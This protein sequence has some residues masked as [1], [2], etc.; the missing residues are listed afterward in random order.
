M[1]L[2]ANAERFSGF[3]DLYDE[4]RP[5]PPREIARLLCAY[6]AVDRPALVVDLG[7]GTGLSSR[8]CASWAAQV[9]GVEPSEDMRT[10][11]ERAT[12]SAAAGRRVRY[13]SGWSHATGLPPGRADVVVAVQALHWMDPRPTFAEV[14]RLLRAGGVFAA[15]DCDWPPSVGSARAEQAWERCRG[16]I[17]VYEARLA[18][19]LG[20]PALRAPLD[21]DASL[22]E[23]FGRDPNKGRTM[24]VGVQAWSK[25]EHLGRMRAS[26]EFQWCGEVC[27]LSRE[28][29]DADRFIALL[30]SQGDLQ[31]L[32]KHGL[33]EQL[34]GVDSFA[35]DAR[36][37]LGPGARPFWFTYRVRLGIV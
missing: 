33:T 22:P 35:A 16:T 34:L 13:V 37:E 1:E 25:D 12:I 5:T 36:Q 29:G 7:S 10:R 23:H 15:M 6:A 11:A 14:A 19:G 9:V 17:R 20:G 31:T 3:S 30:R 8:W 27:A 18:Q 28:Q 26:G 21:A 4:V 32:L 2:E 24:A